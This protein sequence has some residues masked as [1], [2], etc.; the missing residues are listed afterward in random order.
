[1][2]AK[3]SGKTVDGWLPGRRFKAV[4]DEYGGRLQRQKMVNEA[5]LL[6]Y[7]ILRCARSSSAT[8]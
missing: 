8:R 3:S 4:L 2:E 6:L 1:M 7:R 5:D